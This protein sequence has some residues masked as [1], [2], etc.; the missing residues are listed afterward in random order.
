MIAGVR[1]LA[2]CEKGAPVGGL[3]VKLGIRG[4]RIVTGGDGACRSGR[5]LRRGSD[6]AVGEAWLARTALT[7]GDGGP[8]LDLS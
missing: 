7:G 6:A 3:V 1:G 4:R 2:Q 8:G 5:A